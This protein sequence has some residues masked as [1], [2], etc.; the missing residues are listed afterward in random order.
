MSCLQNLIFDFKIFC[1]VWP[2]LMCFDNALIFVI[3]TDF[4]RS[5][6]FSLASNYLVS[7]ESICR[8]FLGLFII[9]SQFLLCLMKVYYYEQSNIFPKLHFSQPMAFFFE[10]AKIFQLNLIEIS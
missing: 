5:T 10:L 7:S 3:L 9:R 4:L 8:S 6:L 1:I 2:R